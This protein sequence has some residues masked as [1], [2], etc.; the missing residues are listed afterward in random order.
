MARARVVAVLNAA[1]RIAWVISLVWM[2][3]T[4]W[5]GLTWHSG[6]RAGMARWVS[7]AVSRSAFA[8]RRPAVSPSWSLLVISTDT[9]GGGD[10][11]SSRAASVSASARAYLA[12]EARTLV[13]AFFLAG[14]G[15][16]RVGSSSVVAYASWES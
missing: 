7:W 3:R 14:L 15:T 5:P 11:A 12:L 4:C 8:A 6:S 1:M 16:I 13:W 10:T 9:P 2:S